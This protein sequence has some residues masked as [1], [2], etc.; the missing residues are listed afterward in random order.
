MRDFPFPF[1][2]PRGHPPSCVMGTESLSLSLDS[3]AA[4]A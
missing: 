1:R 3:K 2:R 4:E